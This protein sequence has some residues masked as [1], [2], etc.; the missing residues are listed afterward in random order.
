MK[1]G[2]TDAQGI[3]GQLSLW[4]NGGI[5]VRRGSAGK[6]SMQLKN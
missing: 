2:K 3:G 5:W 4:L 1:A 6:D